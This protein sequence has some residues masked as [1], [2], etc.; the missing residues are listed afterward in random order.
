M[1]YV[2]KEKKAKIAAALKN[3]VPKNVKY[4]LAVD[5]HS[6]IVCTIYS[7]PIDLLG[8]YLSGKGYDNTDKTITYVDVNHYHY[9]QIL[10][11]SPEALEL[12]KSIVDCLNIDNYDRSDIMTDYFDVGHY[13][14][15]RLGR[16]DKPFTVN[17]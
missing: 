12:I 5:N 7:A 15:L 2:S 6:S 3:V 13:I 1:A 4:S 14:N 10:K 9:E 16:W 8:A 11:D 17:N